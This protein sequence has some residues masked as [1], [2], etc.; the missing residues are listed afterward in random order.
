MRQS[1]MVVTP[2]FI[3]PHHQQRQRAI[4]G[5][6]RCAD[7]CWHGQVRVRAQVWL[8]PDSGK[9]TLLQGKLPNLMR[10]TRCQRLMF[11]VLRASRSRQGGQQQRLARLAAIG[12]PWFTGR[13]R[14]QTIAAGPLLT[15]SKVALLMTPTAVAF[16]RKVVNDTYTYKVVNTGNVAYRIVIKIRTTGP[17]SAASFTG[18]MV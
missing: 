9:T 8:H 10:I 5:V 4:T 13:N 14:T 15:V 6:T 3:L 12:R 1:L 2:W 7:H 18:R 11:I 17:R 16:R